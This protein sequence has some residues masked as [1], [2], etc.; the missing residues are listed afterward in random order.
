VLTDRTTLAGCGCALLALTLPTGGPLNNQNRASAAQGGPTNTIAFASFGPLNT[1][2]FIAERDGT[3]PTAFLPDP[4]LDYNASFSSDSEWV[5]FTSQRNGSADIYRARPDASSLTRLTDDPAFDDQAALSPD[6]RY[7]AFV[8][9]RTGNADVWVLDLRTR[10]L[11]NITDHPAGDFRPAWSP[12]GERLAF[13]SDRDLPGP[14]FEFIQVQLTEIYIVGRDGSALRRVTHAK[15]VAGTPAWSRDG[16]SVVYYQAAAAEARA[17]V[18]PDGTSQLNTF[19]IASSTTTTLTEGP[20]PKVF[21]QWLDGTVAYF[22]RT[23]EGRLRFSDGRT[24]AV[25]QFGHPSW[26]AD[27]RRMVYHRELGGDW[28]PYQR[29]FSRDPEFAM[30]RTG[31]FPHYSPDGSRLTVIS[32]RRASRAVR[33]GITVMNSDGSA[34]SLL[35]DDPERSALGPVWS[36][37]SDRVAF[38]LGQFFPMTQGFA[39]AD[40]AL[41][42]FRSRDLTVLTDGSTNTGFPS[43][44]P[45]GERLVYREWRQDASRLLIVD[46]RTKT[47]TPLLADFGRVNFPSWSPIGDLVQFTSD[48]DGDFELYTIDVKTM[49]IRRLTHSPGNDA[50]GSWSAD[51]RWIAFSSVRQGFKDEAAL[52]PGNPQ[53]AGDL[54]AVR[55]DGSDIRVLTDNPFEEATTAWVPKRR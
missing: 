24:G 43:W 13:S 26:A 35:F 22:D 54:Y 2:L 46:V 51:G 47:I 49:Q 34:P 55:A 25:G 19:E 48:R 37:G 18:S 52:H 1:D 39:P 42:D 36:P 4:G 41:L 7:L 23:G 27:G 53:A 5:I 20:G 50:H 40:I 28:P 33:N 3:N 12:D 9:T 32:G 45:D 21:P 29:V 11:R 17:L 44:S 30:I 14:R 38:G 10:Q 8:S 31:V 16:R 15:G 6:G